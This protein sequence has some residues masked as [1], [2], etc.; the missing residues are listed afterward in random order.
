MIKKT[1]ILVFTVFL[2]NIAFSQLTTENVKIFGGTT[3][4]QTPTPNMPPKGGFEFNI[5]HRFDFTDLNETNFFVNN[6]FGLDGIANIRFNFNFILHERLSVGIGRTKNKK[7]VEFETKLSIL[8]QKKDKSMPLSIAA[9][10]NLAYRTD[11]IQIPEYAYFTDSVTQFEYTHP[12]RMSYIGQ[13]I[14]ARK[15]SNWL[16]LQVA[17]AIVH[18]NLVEPEVENTVYALPVGGWIKTGFRHGV[19]FEYAYIHNK[20]EDHLDAFSVAF[21]VRPVGHVF[22]IVLSNSKA[23]LGQSLYTGQNLDII[24]DRQFYL[25]FNIH[26]NLYIKKG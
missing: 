15:F 4:I 2:Y 23:M 19:I 8:E 20:P 18:H 1:I 10:F 11:E 5:N 26:R 9:Y 25:G 17:P 14:I 3:L 12:H 13:L 24:N 16:S 21:E 6:F 7:Q 22:Q